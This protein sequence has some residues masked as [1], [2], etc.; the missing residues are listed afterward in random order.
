MTEFRSFEVEQSR[1]SNHSFLADND[2]GR[3][4]ESI[5]SPAYSNPHFGSDLYRPLVNESPPANFVTKTPQDDDQHKSATPPSVK[6]SSKSPLKRELRT[7]SEWEELFR[8][9]GM[10]TETEAQHEVVRE[11]KRSARPR[12][13]VKADLPSYM[14]G[15]VSYEGRMQ[16]HDRPPVP[17]P[18]TA[19]RTRQPKKD[20]HFKSST[21]IN[22]MDDIHSEMKEEDVYIPLAARIKLFEQSL[23]GGAQAPTN[24]Q[25]SSSSLTRPRSP[26]LLT[27]HRPS[28]SQRPT[29]QHQEKRQPLSNSSSNTSDHRRSRSNRT[30]PSAGSRREPG[31]SITPP[32][33]PPSESST[34]ASKKQ[35]MNHERTTVKPFR[36]ATDERALHHQKA[37][38]AKLDLWKKKEQQIV[39]DAKKAVC[40]APVQRHRGTKRKVQEH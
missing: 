13:T 18:S 28:S 39:E 4:D 1:R 40:A 37:F 10:S 32:A 19:M 6:R 31:S 9:K 27:R 35:K 16:R 23:R 25:R 33:K 5:V 24:P 34:R 3:P 12:E 21:R 22:A 8:S 11:E 38:K 14:R 26:K 17:K 15:T 7:P 2:D 30:H 20:H 29:P 36:F